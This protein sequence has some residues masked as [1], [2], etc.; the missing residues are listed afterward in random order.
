MLD[1]L[2]ASGE[3]LSIRDL[4]EMLRLRHPVSDSVR[5]PAYTTVST[6]L[7]NLHGKGYLSRR[8]KEGRFL[9]RPRYSR[10]EVLLAILGSIHASL[11][12]DDDLW[13]EAA[14]EVSHAR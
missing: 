1:L 5:P 7:R 11:A 6:V 3:E 8:T 12:G 14:K 13:M 9:Y 2:W 10:R 4:Y